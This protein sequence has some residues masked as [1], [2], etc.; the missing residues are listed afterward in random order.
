MLGDGSDHRRV[1]G[2]VRGAWAAR[3]RAIPPA[4]MHLGTPPACQLDSHPL[5]H[6][7]ARLRPA[8]MIVRA[9]AATA[10]RSGAA[11]ACPCT[12]PRRRRCRC[13]MPVGAAACQPRPCGC[14]PGPATVT[15][16]LTV[17]VHFW[18]FVQSVPT[19]P[20]L[21]QQPVSMLPPRRCVPASFRA[22]VMPE[23]ELAKVSYN[24]MGVLCCDGAARLQC[25]C[26]GK[27]TATTKRA[28]PTAD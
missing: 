25:Q 16:W 8:S 7:T 12:S 18:W 19:G 3:E 20:S 9:S 5:G 10:R 14:P 6:R 1:C 28:E 15:R 22:V 27:G 21:L 26:V 24:S 4:S 13:L 2:R 23:A 11:D 17:D